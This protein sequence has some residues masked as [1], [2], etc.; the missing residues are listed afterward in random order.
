VITKLA[1][2]EE[3]FS[4][5]PIGYLGLTRLESSLEGAVDL[6]AS[7]RVVQALGVTRFKVD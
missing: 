2:I 1:G 6:V 4:P 5:W 7:C 3:I